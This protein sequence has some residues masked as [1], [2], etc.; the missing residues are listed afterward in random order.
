MR[1]DSAC[2][3]FMPINVALD[4]DASNPWSPLVR[5]SSGRWFDTR[6]CHRFEA[7]QHSATVVTMDDIAKLA[8]LL[9]HETAEH[10]DPFEKVAPQHEWWYWYAA[11]LHAWQHGRTSPD[12]TAY[13]A[14][15]GVEGLTGPATP[16]RT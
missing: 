16:A 2:V 1:A 14:G 4:S 15:T 13:G 7:P 10:H 9:I 11:Y 12:A 8:E 6:D 3:R 5:C